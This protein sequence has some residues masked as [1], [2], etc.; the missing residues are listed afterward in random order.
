MSTRAYERCPQVCSPHRLSDR[1]GALDDLGDHCRN[2]C[3][4]VENRER[5]SGACPLGG[6][7]MNKGCGSCN[8]NK[9]ARFSQ[10][11]FAVSRDERTE[12]A[13]KSISCARSGQPRWCGIDR[14]CRDAVR[15]VACVPL[16]EHGDA[17]TSRC[18]NGP[19]ARLSC[20]AVDRLIQKSTKFTKVRGNY[21]RA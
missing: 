11:F 3:A 21:T 2:V 5:P 14:N 10:H 1:C 6:C 12:Y 20:D 7:T 18:L 8:A 4:E 13:A 16:D 17:E 9:Q 15:H 19:L